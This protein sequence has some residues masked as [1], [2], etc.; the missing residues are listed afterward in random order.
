MIE[1]KAGSKCDCEWCKKTYPAIKWL[2]M[3]APPEHYE[4]ISNALH[5]HELIEIDIAF[6]RGK[7]REL[8]STMKES[9]VSLKNGLEN[10]LKEIKL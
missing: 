8:I 2:K 7:A 9:A 5:H 4:A 10:L 3:N 1:E 6:C